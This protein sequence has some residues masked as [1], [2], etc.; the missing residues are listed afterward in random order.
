[1]SKETLLAEMCYEFYKDLRS[2]ASN[3]DILSAYMKNFISVASASGEINREKLALE[4][5]K[6]MLVRDRRGE[7]D[8]MNVV[9]WTELK[10]SLLSS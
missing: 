3:S 7:L 4:F 1:M 2:Q 8:L 5:T 9:A 6:L 10:H